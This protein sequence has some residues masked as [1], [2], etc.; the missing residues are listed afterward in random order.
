[1]SNN[2]PMNV[3]RAK[4]KHWNLAVDSAEFA[5]RLDQEDPFGTYRHQF[6]FPKKSDLPYVD[7][8][9]LF[10]DN[11]EALYLC[12][13][14]LG[15]EPKTCKK[16]VKEV[17][18]NWGEKGVHS[19]FHGYMPAALSDLVPKTLMARIVGA[20]PNEVALMNALTVNLHLLLSTFYRPSQRRHKIIIEEHAFSSDMF[21]VKSQIRFHGLS[22]DNSLIML[23]TR[24][25]E[26]LLR[27]EDILEVIEKEGDNVMVAM[28]PAVQYYTG[29]LLNVQRLTKAAQNKGIV[30]GVD[31]AHAVGNVPIYLDKW[32]VD[33][34]A[35]C[36][37]KY[38]CSGA[39]GIGGIYVNE[40][41]TENGGS[42]TF[43]MLQGWWGNSIKTKFLMKDDFDPSIGADMFKLSNPSP[44]LNAMLMASLD[45]YN[46][47]SV[48]ELKEKQFLLTGYLE[49]MIKSYFPRKRTSKTRHP[50]NDNNNLSGGMPS[51]EIITP[52]DPDQRG[53]QLSLIFSVP[54]TPV[55]EELQKRG[56]VC[57]IRMPS[58]MRVAPVPIYNSFTD[59][60]KFVSILYEIFEGFDIEKR[61]Y[62]NCGEEDLFT[63][64]HGDD[65]LSMSSSNSSACPSPTTVSDSDCDSFNGSLNVL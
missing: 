54:L 51:V 24:P 59:V 36:T 28:L 53:A 44:V 35:W 4:A 14:S 26:H 60:H 38:L 40:Q 50:S 33:F 45:I 52:A 21:V 57:D 32:N 10:D 63:E 15:L 43:P 64:W 55:Q 65:N 9:R 20:K 17:L 39:G 7:K 62:D 27:E 13:Q 31:L 46:Q 48:E 12:G 3:F 37:Y 47:T 29:Q 6:I 2:K 19:H 34:A 49:Y 16:N 42:A 8:K 30:V 11:E 23:K 1:M 25:G 56:V 58:V 22:P 41:Y 61:L 5:M 18:K